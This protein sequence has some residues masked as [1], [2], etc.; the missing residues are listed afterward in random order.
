MGKI[1]ATG[2]R[3]PILPWKNFAAAKWLLTDNLLVCF[4]EQKFYCCFPNTAHRESEREREM[5]QQQF[6]EHDRQTG[7]ATA[8]RQTSPTSTHHATEQLQY[9]RSA[10]QPTA[11]NI[12]SS[13]KQK[14]SYR[15]KNW[16]RR[17]NP[18]MLKPPGR[19]HLFDPP[20]IFSRIFARC[21]LDF[22]SPS[23]CCLR[24]IKTSHPVAITGRILRNKLTKHTSPGCAVT[25]SNKQELS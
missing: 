8:E 16:Q 2:K 25:S 9:M 11:K 24:T 6:G 18:A 13:N 14:H 19:G 20:A 21:S 5:L 23:L 10:R 15:S 22:H 12:S 7:R 1:T 3:F 4:F 17:R